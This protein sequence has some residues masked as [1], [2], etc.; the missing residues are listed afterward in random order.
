MTDQEVLQR[1]DQ[2]KSIMIAVATGG[3]RIAEVQ[4]EF[5]ARYD[6]FA[7]E[8]TNRQIE[9]PLPYR[10]LWEWYGRWSSGDLP[11]WQSRRQFVNDLVGDF[12]RRLRTQPSARTP[13][14]PTGW[15]RVDRTVTEIRKRLEIARTEEHFQAVGLLCREALISLGQAVYDATLHPTLDG[16]A[17]SATDAKRMLEA[18]VAATFAGSAHEYL[19]KHARA[20]CDLAIHL[21][22]R[23]TATFRDA[24][25]CTEA[26]TSVI[27]LIAIMAGLRDP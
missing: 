21:Q 14:E 6:E 15:D 12:G 11:S 10:D 25:A 20:A 27:N 17:A 3:P 24:A 2:L 26:T 19:R 18:Y 4:A 1:L 7:T 8:L 16:V 13:T 22:H 5:A 9:N 23:R